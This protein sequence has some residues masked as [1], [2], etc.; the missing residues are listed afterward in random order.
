V[1]DLAD[2]RP[3][4]MDAAAQW[5]GLTENTLIRARKDEQFI[6]PHSADASLDGGR[7]FSPRRQFA[8]MNIKERQ[9]RWAHADS[10]VFADR[11]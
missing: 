5:D 2:A 11:I 3:A 10:T 9:A 1:S 6:G 7:I 8:K 4:I